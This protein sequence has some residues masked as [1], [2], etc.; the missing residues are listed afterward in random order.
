M[1]E[2]LN[3]RELFLSV[4]ERMKAGGWRNA[5]ETLDRE[6]AAAL[7]TIDANLAA[8][9][10]EVE[11]RVFAEVGIAGRNVRRIVKKRV[12]EA[13]RPMKA[14]RNV[15][16]RQLRKFKGQLAAIIAENQ[17]GMEADE[18][19]TAAVYAILEEE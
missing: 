5:V 13:M 6:G 12:D 8:G 10:A 4:V 7:A 19:L 11:A 14:R 3:L 18:A 1:V 2:D 9:R 15:F 16:E 17:N